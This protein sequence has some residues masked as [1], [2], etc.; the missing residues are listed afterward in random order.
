MIKIS[1][2]GDEELVARFVAFRG[3]IRA[4]LEN[5]IRKLTM[6]LVRKVKAEKLSGQVLNRK[7][8]SL[9]RSV[10]P[11]FDSSE[12][13]FT[14]IV[15]TNVNYGRFWELGFDRAVGAGARGGPRNMLEKAKAR[16]FA[17]HPPGRKHYG[18]RSFLGSALDDMRPTIKDQHSD[19]VRK[20]TNRS[21]F[22]R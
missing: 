6:D 15:G 22:D 14:G 20:A 21:F 17:K 11:S 1:I 10:T 9:S 19:V 16:Y 7:T 2:D 18:P 12:T 4:E 8:G 13:S 3:D 5:A